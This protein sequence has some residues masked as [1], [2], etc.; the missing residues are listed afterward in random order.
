[1]RTARTPSPASLGWPAPTTMLP[2]RKAWT[3]TSALWSGAVCTW[4]TGRT[5]KP[6]PP[7]PRPTRGPATR[8][9]HAYPAHRRGKDGN[10]QQD[11]VEQVLQDADR[12]LGRGWMRRLRRR[13][14]GSKKATAAFLAMIASGTEGPAGSVCSDQNRCRLRTQRRSFGVGKSGIG[15]IHDAMLSWLLRCRL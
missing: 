9:L 4:S 3:T 2:M 11:R 7:R 5:G 10:G 14:L 15:S 13:V 8:G 1:M 6:R 12:W